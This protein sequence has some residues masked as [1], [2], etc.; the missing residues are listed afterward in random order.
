MYMQQYSNVAALEQF[1]L[2]GQELQAVDRFCMQAKDIQ[3]QSGFAYTM[4]SENLSIN[5]DGIGPTTRAVRSCAKNLASE[6]CAE[7]GDR[8]QLLYSAVLGSGKSVDTVTIQGLPTEL[9]DSAQLI[10]FEGNE[11]PSI[12]INWRWAESIA[13]LKA[14]E[15]AMLNHLLTRKSNILPVDVTI[16][17]YVFSVL[18]YLRMRQQGIARMK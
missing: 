12:P 9:I 17:T 1:H 7:Y 8:Y 6:S 15:A 5:N 3:S 18:G 13:A 11:L 10:Q 16:N 2:Q 4:S 14:F